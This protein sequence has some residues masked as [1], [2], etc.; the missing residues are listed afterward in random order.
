MR[1]SFFGSSLVSAYWNGA[2]T[3]Y[4][5]LLKALAR[6]GH[7]VSF[8]EPDAFQRQAH[9]DIADPDWAEVTVFEPTPEAMERVLR[10]AGQADVVVKFSGVGVLDR[11]LE[12]AVVEL[13]RPDRLAVFWD[14]DAP[15]TLDSMTA[16]PA[17]PL[18][19]HVP[20]YDAVLTYGGGDAVLSAYRRFGARLCVPIYNALDPETHH[21]VRAI[22]RFACDH[23]PFLAT[24][25]RTARGPRVEEFFLGAAARL[26]GQEHPESCATAGGDKPMPCECA[27]GS[28]M[29][30]RATTTR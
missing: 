24:G 28:D 23:R 21:P 3:Y 18:R 20:R 10:K 5:G 22:E 26:A 6:R 30:I 25:C 29:S 14:V 19:G 16:D 27:R 1:L 8:F 2:A 13:R 7:E 11:E 9:R 17:D 4:R 15:A 12:R